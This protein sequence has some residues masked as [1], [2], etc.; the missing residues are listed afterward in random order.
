MRAGDGRWAEHR[1]RGSAIGRTD[2]A[3][4]RRERDDASDRAGGRVHVSVRLRGHHGRRRRDS[5]EQY[6]HRDGHQ[7]A[8]DA[9]GADQSVG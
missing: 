3:G 7:G 2:R 5:V 9:G 8:P 1:R 4:H 6:F